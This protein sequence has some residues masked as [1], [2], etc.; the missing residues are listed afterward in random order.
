MKKSALTLGILILF[1]SSGFIGY[2]DTLFIPHSAFTPETEDTD[3][4]RMA[5][6]I[7]NDSISAKTFS[8]PVYLPQG[9]V[10][11]GM[12]LF[13]EDSAS[14]YIQCSLF[15]VNPDAGLDQQQFFVMTSSSSPG[16]KHIADWTLTAGTRTVNH[17]VFTYLLKLY[18]FSS[19]LCG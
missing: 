3:Y 9:A 4:Y 1:L 13:Y 10:I 11:D 17:N 18:W 14:Y 5:A 12:F 2:A 19:I 15:R 6:Y 16:I 8:A 7:R